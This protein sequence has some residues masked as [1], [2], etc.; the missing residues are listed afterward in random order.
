MLPIPPLASAAYAA[1]QV[2]RQTEEKAQQV[3]A[4]QFRKKN[5]AAAADEYVH[6]VESTDEIQPIHDEDTKQQQP[7]K[8]PDR[9]GQPAADEDD[10]MPH[11]DLTA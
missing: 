6:T 1:T 9:H 10:E 5:S 3:R 11:L 2:Q 8:K 4:S 7:R